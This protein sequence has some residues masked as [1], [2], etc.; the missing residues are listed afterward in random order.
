[1][2]DVTGVSVVETT[3]HEL[4]QRLTR[5]L[6]V[7]LAG[8]ALRERSSGAFVV[9][10]IDSVRPVSTSLRVGARVPLSASRKCATSP[11]A[12]SMTVQGGLPLVEPATSLGPAE[13]GD[14]RSLYLV[15]IRLGTEA[16]GVLTLGEMRALDREPFTQEKWERCRAL[17]DEFV[18]ANSHVWEAMRLRWQLVAMSSI[19]RLVREVLEARSFAELLAC[20]TSEVAD[21]LGAPVRG[22]F[23]R[24]CPGGRLEV[25]ARRD[26]PDALTDAE[27]GQIVSALVRFGGHGEWPVGVARVSSDPLDPLYGE[28]E[29]GEPWTRVSLPL[30]RDGRLLGVVCLYVGEDLVLGHAELESLR[31]RAEIATLGMTLVESWLETARERERLGRTAWELQQTLVGVVRIVS[32]F[33]RTRF[34]E[35]PQALDA[36]VEVAAGGPAAGGMSVDTVLTELVESVASW[37]GGSA[38]PVEV[39]QLVRHAIELV[40]AQEVARG[41]PR[42]GALQLACD[43][44]SEPLMVDASMALIGVLV[45]AIESAAASMPEGGRVTLR[46]A[47]DNGHV[48]ISVHDARSGASTDV[49]REAS[50]GGGAALSVVTA[51]VRRYGGSVTV[52]SSGSD[53]GTSVVMRFPAMAVAQQGG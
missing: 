30:I 24:V 26:M 2:H 21:W 14:L 39:N 49:R 12:Q 29:A 5:T 42:S 25:V 31:R 38:G 53:G 33:L 8:V 4:A 16:I 6:P 28:T 41:G 34:A 7:T 52:A 50:L 10:T 32:S 18:T 44:A 20:C 9:K 27:T 13:A 46:T 40:R 35:R 11:D 48:V 36:G 37:E 1:M 17:V 23:F 15:P 19:C 47:R 45:H 51:F 43:C 22:I 3:V